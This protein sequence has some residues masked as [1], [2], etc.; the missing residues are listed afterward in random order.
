MNHVI[1]VLLKKG[2]FDDQT[3]AMTESVL[4]EYLDWADPY[5]VSTA[6]RAGIDVRNLKVLLFLNLNFYFFLTEL[7]ML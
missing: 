2:R 4:M 7:R 5:S 1:P 6:L 3:G